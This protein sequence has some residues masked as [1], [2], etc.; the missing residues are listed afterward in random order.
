MS[1]LTR[2][3]NFTQLEE[4]EEL[5][6]FLALFGEEVV[7]TIN[8]R[9]DFETNFACQLVRVTFSAASTDTA[10]AHS[11]GRVPTGFLLYYLDSPVAIYNG[12]T[13]NTSTTFYL[14]ASNPATAKVIL[15]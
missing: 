10:V 7:L 3:T 8:G 9:L 15:F 2:S 14:R 5:K 6:K 4:I 13:A 11:L 1:K 12:A